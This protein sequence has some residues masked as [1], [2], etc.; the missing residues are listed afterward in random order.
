M[1]WVSALPYD[2]MPKTT[3][4]KKKRRR[5]YQAHSFGESRAWPVLVQF[6]LEEALFATVSRVEVPV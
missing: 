2:A 4:F 1:V 6:S 5:D 3:N